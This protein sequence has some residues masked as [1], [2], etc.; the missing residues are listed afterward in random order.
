MK[1]KK[2]RKMQQAIT[3]KLRPVGGKNFV[4]NQSYLVILR[5]MDK[6]INKK[7]EGVRKPT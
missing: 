1:K 3:P 2:E 5:N 6:L 7:I 4:S